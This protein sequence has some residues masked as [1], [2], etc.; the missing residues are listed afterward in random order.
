[1]GQNPVEWSLWGDQVG[2]AGGMVGGPAGRGCVLYYKWAYG[3][4]G[5]VGPVFFIHYSYFA[6][7]FIH[8]LIS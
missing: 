2:G 4:M 1:M 6:F 7:L 5:F 3:Q 8:Y